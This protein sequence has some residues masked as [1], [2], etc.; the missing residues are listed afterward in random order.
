[1]NDENLTVQV[2][3]FPQ[4]QVRVLWSNIY[5]MLRIFL[6]FH[7]QCLSAFNEQLLIN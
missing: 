2:Y 1:M 5:E 7:S 6:K 4:R 3:M